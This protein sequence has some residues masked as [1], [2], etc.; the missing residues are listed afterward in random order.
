MKKTKKMKKTLLSLL[1]PVPVDL[2]ILMKALC[3]AVESRLL[4]K[5]CSQRKKKKRK[6]RRRQYNAH[7]T[8]QTHKIQT[9]TETHTH[10]THTHTTNNFHDNNIDCSNGYFKFEQLV[11]L[12]LLALPLNGLRISSKLV[13][14][15]QLV[16]REAFVDHIFY[17]SGE[18]ERLKC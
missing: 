3:G 14:R 11:F 10:T 13:K 2:L 15:L 1:L 9:H 16:V 12:L 17:G 6:E 18:V 8:N 4:G 5:A 7:T